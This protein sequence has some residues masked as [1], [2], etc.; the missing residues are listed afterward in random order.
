MGTVDLYPICCDKLVRERL[1]RGVSQAKAR[2]IMLNILEVKK[3]E[4]EEVLELMTLNDY[5][6]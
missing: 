2:T 6:I 3:E 1:E 5:K 4:K